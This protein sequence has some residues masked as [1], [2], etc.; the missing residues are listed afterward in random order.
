MLDNKT[1]TRSGPTSPSRTALAASGIG[2]SLPAIATV[3]A[4]ECV[5]KEG[6]LIGQKRV[7]LFSGRAAAV[8]GVFLNP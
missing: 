7:L 2:G 4:S 1:A 5:Q 8:A 3:L 6:E